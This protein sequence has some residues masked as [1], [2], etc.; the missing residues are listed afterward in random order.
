MTLLRHGKQPLII[1]NPDLCKEWDYEKNASLTPNDVTRGLRLHVWWKCSSGHSWKAAINPRSKGVGCP[2]CA[3]HHVIKGVNDLQTLSPELAKEWH[4]EK[5]GDLKPSDV[6]LSSGKK[7]W[8]KCSNGHE[9]E[10]SPNSRVS[11]KEGFSECPYCSGRKTLAGYNDF[12]TWCHNNDCDYLLSEWDYEKNTITP[13]QISPKNNIKI[14]WICSLG[15]KWE[16]SLGSRTSQKS[17]CPYCS[18]PPKRV[19]VGFNDFKTWCNN[20]GRLELLDEWDYSKNLVLP[21]DITYSG[22]GKVC[23]K[24]KKGHEWQATTYIRIKGSGC[25]Y[26]SGRYAIKG[27][28]DLTITDPELC[29][30]WDYDKNGDLKPSDVKAGSNKKVWWKCEFGHEWKTTVANRKT[31]R[32]CPFCSRSGSSMPE[33]GIAYYIGKICKVEQRVKICNKEIDIFLPEHKIGIEYDGE[34]YHKGRASHDIIKSRRLTNAGINLFRIKESNTNAVVNDNTILFDGNGINSNY[35]WALEQLFI[36]LY[37][38]TNNNA[39]QSIQIDLESD[40]IKIRERFNLY[41]KKNS[42]A[43]TNPELISEWNYSKNGQLKPEMFFHGSSMKVWWKCFKG[44]EWKATV[45]SRACNGSGCPYCSGR[46][47]IIGENDLMTTNSDLVAEWHPT[48]NG[49]L[50]PIDVMAGSNIKVW[51]ICPNGHEWESLIANRAKGIGCPYCSGRYAIKGETDLFTT[52]PE[53]RDEWDYEKNDIVPTDIKAG[54]HKKVWWQCKLGHSWLASIV[55]RKT[56]CGCPYCSGKRVLAGFNDLNTTN[57]DVAAEWDYEKNGELTPDKVLTNSN[58]KVWW[59]CKKGHEWRTTVSHRTDKITGTRCP[60]CFGGIARPVLC[61]E[62]G[63][64][65]PNMTAASNA[66]G[67]TKARIVHSCKDETKKKTS[68]GYHWEYID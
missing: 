57:P 29:K 17:G 62:T 30:E 11:K 47:A 7:I 48:K 2:Y 46:Q 33:Q 32:N 22:G 5:N 67:A 53:L 15:H 55:D 64:V 4:P 27:E 25:P 66:T 38:I 3:G 6:M 65:Y 9:W 39:F 26:C 13:S 49:N 63:I 12:G 28:N 34:F 50:K 18:N 60:Y 52:N 54:S 23:W 40:L 1:T 24:C 43:F 31:G 44:H 59:K 61:V 21:T 56:G 51:W 19:L 8:W 68:G 45:L 37:S 35:V 20:N 42:L 58:K 41:K 10:I 14:W 36:R 16:C